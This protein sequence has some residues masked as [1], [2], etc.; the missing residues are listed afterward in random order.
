MFKKLLA[1]LLLPLVVGCSENDKN[2]TNADK[3]TYSI[4]T[5]ADYPP[6]EFLKDG[7]IVGFDID[8]VHAI[9]EKMGVKITVNDMSFDAILGSLKS[10]RID[11]AISSITPT[12]ERREAVDFSDEYY[13][14]NRVL[15]CSDLSPVRNI[16]DLTGLAI[17]V[18]AGS[19]YEIYANGD[20][21]QI[22]AGITVKSLPRLPELLQE[23]KTH[24]LSCL[25][26][27]EKEAEGLMKNTQGLRLVKID[28]ETAG[29]AIALPKG[30]KLLEKVNEALKQLNA[31][32]TIEKLQQKWLQK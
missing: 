25:L 16:T 9:A 27:G 30:S 20:L 24:R 26:M 2:S 6:F 15:V 32:G 23:L 7:K 3:E 5:S 8:L 18:Q 14:T 10:N 19:I 1:A 28:D 17:G 21:H 11:M 22:A 4:A 12:P 31:D 29:F 13:S